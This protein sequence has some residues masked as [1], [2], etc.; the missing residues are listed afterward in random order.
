MI[1]RYLAALREPNTCVVVIGCG[2]KDSHL[3]QPILSAVRTNPHLRLLV[4]NSRT[5]ENAEAQQ[6]S[7]EHVWGELL[8][9]AREGED[10]WLINADFAQFAEIIPD[11]RALSPSQRLHR[12]IRNIAGGRGGDDWARG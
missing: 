9:L 8:A 6:G 2:F 10:V 11:L 12:E 7:E 5:R 4:V 1:S 3:S